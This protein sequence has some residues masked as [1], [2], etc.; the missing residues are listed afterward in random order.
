MIDNKWMENPVLANISP[1]KM[2]ILTRILDGAGDRD[3][4]QMLTYFIK[5]T[6][7][8]SRNGINFSNAETDA[9]LGVLKADMSP[10]EIKKI[11]MI[12]KMVANLSKRKL[13]S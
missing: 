1:E 3:A 4:R 9:I 2:E 8:A 6:N 7:L 12:R 13:K 5:E 10:E 11:D